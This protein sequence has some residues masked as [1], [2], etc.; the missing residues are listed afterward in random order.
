MTLKEHGGPVMARQAR[1]IVK[2]VRIVKFLAR[3][4]RANA[5]LFAQIARKIRSF[6]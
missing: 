2:Q 4:G 1:L 5:T 6:K 3:A